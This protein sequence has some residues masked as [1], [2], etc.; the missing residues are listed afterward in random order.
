MKEGEGGN[1]QEGGG[2]ADKD[3]EEEKIRRNWGQQSQEGG[4][5]GGRAEE[6]EREMRPTAPSR[7][8][9]W[10]ASIVEVPSREKDTGSFP[11]AE[12]A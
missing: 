12:K 5:G 10:M 8:K 6:R 11:G 9:S 7:K 1:K 4:R 2:C 3:G